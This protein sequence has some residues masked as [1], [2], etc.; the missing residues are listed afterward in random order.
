MAVVEQLIWGKDGYARAENIRYSEGRT[1]R[2]IAKLY[3][4]E[5]L[6]PYNDNNKEQH[7]TTSYHDISDDFLQPSTD[8]ATSTRPTRDTPLK[9]KCALHTI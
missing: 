8:S 9:I 4:L 6:F 2:P 1:N 5:F 3:P 7:V